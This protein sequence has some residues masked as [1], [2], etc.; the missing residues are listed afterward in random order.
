M[1]KLLFL[2]VLPCMAETTVSDRF[3]DAIRRDDTAAVQAL[4]KANDI[5]L[6]DSRGDTP[7]MYA[8]AAGSEAM[9]RL[10]LDAGADVNTKNSFEATPLMWA[11]TSLPRVKL[12]IDRGADVKARSKAGHTPV[13]L[14]CSTA[15]NLEV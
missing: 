15:G 1:R 12:L 2:F 3:Y 7:L 8:A 11:I 5:N 9:M 14:A 10:L 6:K 13:Q 4:L